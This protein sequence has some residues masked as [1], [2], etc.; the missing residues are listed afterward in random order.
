MRNQVLCNPPWGSGRGL[1][2]TI[3]ADFHVLV[4]K[5]LNHQRHLSDFDRSLEMADR[6]L[7]HSRSGR[8]FNVVQLVCQ[9][10]AVAP[11]NFCD[12]PH[13]RSA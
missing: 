8:L 9:P 13:N 11:R 3:R 10:A 12:W 4:T 1:V 5:P 2:A 6:D 7:S